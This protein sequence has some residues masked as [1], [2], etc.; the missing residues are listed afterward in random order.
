MDNNYSES[1][2]IEEKED[3]LFSSVAKS[4]YEAEVVE[5]DKENLLV[6]SKCGCSFFNKNDDRVCLYC[7]EECEISDK[8]INMANIYYLPFDKSLDDVKDIY[9]KYI[10]LK[11]FAPFACRKKEVYENIKKV[12]IPALLRN[13][14]VNGEII[15]Y[16]A[17]K[18]NGDNLVKYEVGH[19]VNVDFDNI[20]ISLYSKIDNDTYPVLSDYE[21]SRLTLYSNRELSDSDCIISDMNEDEINEKLN[22]LINKY[23]VGLVRD[24]INHNKKKIKENNS[25]IDVKSEQKV[26]LPAYLINIKNRDKNIIGLINAQNGKI[27]MNYDI[28]IINVVIFSIILFVLIFGLV[29]LI[30]CII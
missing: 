25:I 18:G 23:V 24:N 28:D 27:S 11:L 7:G 2:I 16:A 6:C 9:K 26:L 13:C 5:E 30:A 29:F 21:Y 10:K 3:Y 22:N 15:F 12:Y 8:E 17:D 4:S 19:K 20:F 1:N 14:N